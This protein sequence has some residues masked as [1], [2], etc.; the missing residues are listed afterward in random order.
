M[1]ASRRADARTIAPAVGTGGAACNHGRDHPELDMTTANRHV[2][3]WRCLLLALACLLPGIAASQPAAGRIIGYDTG[4]SSIR[5]D[6]VRKID[7]LIFAF[8]SLTH[9][10]ATLEGDAGQRLARLVALKRDHPRLQVVISVGGWAVGGFSEAAGAAAT[11][12][13]FA[14]SAA[15]LVA[16][17]G[18][19]GLDV[20]W[21]YPGH[22]ESG[23]E[24]SPHDR[25]NFTLLLRE[26][27]EAL[28]RRG[29]ADGRHYTLSAALADGP[30]VDHV[31][32]A[33]IAPSLDWVNLMTYDFVNA[34]TPTTGHH[35][36][37]HA[38][39]RAPADA[40]STDRAVREFLAAGVPPR[41]LFIG[42][43]FYG[44]E[45]AGVESNDQGLYQPFA[46]FQGTLPWPQLKADDI[47]RRGYVRHWDSAAQAPWL[48]NPATRRFITYDDPQS[49]AAKAAWAKSR[50]LGGI[51]Y[52]E[53]GLD[54]S[55]ELLDVL[56]R[57]LQPTPAPPPH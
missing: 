28:D 4:R 40:R 35:T 26:Q 56:W 10:R 33:A 27:R 55:G 38:S 29:R 45:F 52:W 22:G 6:D 39:A 25:E 18:A 54:P 34:M 13:R 47:D 17:S 30:F 46:R 32:I 44:R 48:W 49:L 7:V 16:D 15:D 51:M 21:E 2:R 31:D 8:A 23:I 37:L 57:G 20:D 53:Q 42:A 36:A 50:H 14:E 12:R 19:D 3:A 24:S 1:R 41:K 11:R 9:G 5:A 43:A